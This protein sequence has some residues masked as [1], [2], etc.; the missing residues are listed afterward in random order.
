MPIYEYECGKCGDRVE[1]MQKVSESPK[2]KCPTCGEAALK[3]L[4]SAAAFHL[5]GTGWYVTDFRDKHKPKDK[6][7]SEKTESASSE[8][9]SSE[10]KSDGKTES[11]K[12]SKKDTKDK[13][14]TG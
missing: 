9:S 14:A 3:K 2:R 13:A 5:K 6:K 8:S 12:E 7:D 4:I 11:K 10:T 1:I